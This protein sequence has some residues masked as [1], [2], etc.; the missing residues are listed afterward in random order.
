MMQSVAIQDGAFEEA[1][2]DEME[3][4]RGNQVDAEVPDPRGGLRHFKGNKKYTYRQKSQVTYI[5]PK[6][7][8]SSLIGT[9]SATRTSR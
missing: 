6:G 5:H 4:E 3:M 1:H 9:S 8:F 7:Y 2:G